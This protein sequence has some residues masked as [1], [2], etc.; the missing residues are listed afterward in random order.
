METPAPTP[1]VE[2]NFPL[3]TD[4]ITSIVLYYDAP[5]G[6][7]NADGYYAVKVDSVSWIVEDDLD[8]W[9]GDATSYLEASDPNIDADTEL[10]GVA[11]TH[12][13]GGE[14][15]YYAMD[16]DPGQDI[17][18]STYVSPDATISY[19]DIMG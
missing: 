2:G 5:S 12:G 13:S 18:P 19:Y 10:A 3:L 1:S 11:I 7:V 4:N 14:T 9:L 8:L 6:D 16:G 15:E 17:A